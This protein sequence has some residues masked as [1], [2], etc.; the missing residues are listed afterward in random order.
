MNNVF[1]GFYQ[2]AMKHC[3]L[4]S[5]TTV[6]ANECQQTS[7]FLGLMSSHHRFMDVRNYTL[8]S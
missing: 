5:I 2:N 1:D 3:V 8:M 7:I 4:F 6:N